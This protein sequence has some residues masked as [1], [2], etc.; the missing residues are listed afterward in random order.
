MLSSNAAPYSQNDFLIL[1]ELISQAE[2][3][4]RIG[5][6]NG[7]GNGKTVLCIQAQ[8]LSCTVTNDA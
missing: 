6:A 1:E 8:L 2:S 7:Q 5:L 3:Y 4:A